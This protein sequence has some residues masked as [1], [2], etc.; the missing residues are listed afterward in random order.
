MVDEGGRARLVWVTDVLPHAM[1]GLVRGVVERG[2]AEIK[3]TLESGTR[4]AVD[5][6]FE[7][8]GSGARQSSGIDA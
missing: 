7:G 6:G 4:Q 2:I 5:G 8:P 1:A 3:Q